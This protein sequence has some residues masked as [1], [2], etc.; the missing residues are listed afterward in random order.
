MAYPYTSD[1]SINFT[2][3]NLQAS[4]L[5]PEIV[6][7]GIIDNY[8]T[9]N[10]ATLKNSHGVHIS[11]LENFVNSTYLGRPAIPV[12]SGFITNLDIEVISMDDIVGIYNYTTTISGSQFYQ[13][14]NYGVVGET[15]TIE[16]NNIE[17]N[18]STAGTSILNSNSMDFNYLTYTVTGAK[19]EF[20]L[21]D[22][23]VV[24]TDGK[25]DITGNSTTGSKIDF[26]YD[27]G[28]T[29][30]TIISGYGIYQTAG[31]GTSSERTDYHPNELYMHSS[32]PSNT[33]VT[34][35]T[36]T[37]LTTDGSTYT[38]DA[39]SYEF[40]LDDD[41][42]LNSPSGYITNEYFAIENSLVSSKIVMDNVDKSVDITGDLTVT[43]EFKLYS[44]VDV[45]I[46]LVGDADEFVVYKSSSVG[47]T[48][49]YEYNSAKYDE[50]IIGDQT[51]GVGTWDYKTVTIK[52]TEIEIKRYQNPSTTTSM[53]LTNN[54]I[55]FNQSA[56]I[57]TAAAADS[58]TLDTPTGD[59][60]IP[61]LPY[62][63]PAVSGKLWMDPADGHALKVSQG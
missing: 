21:T 29:Y 17:L 2:L 36:N 12:L 54:A 43:N 3:A 55:A 40:D 58:L 7:A 34:T 20:D 63:D 51:N 46:E 49:Y 23:F 56:T 9:V 37:R 62:V 19:Y 24:D 26:N 10:N 60:F 22:D 5:S 41:F 31:Y 32:N 48:T 25:V 8:S 59:I 15:T 27:N 18:N 52:P 61:N 42:I 47:P 39:L 14:A 53:T 16:P 50:H 11:A 1:P 35:Y 45:E 38:V 28:N 6:T 57:S 4:D 13:Y 44:Q 30:T 33:T